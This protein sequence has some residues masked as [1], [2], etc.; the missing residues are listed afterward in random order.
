VNRQS[1]A[2]AAC[3]LAIAGLWS[4][5]RADTQAT[6]T[7]QVIDVE[8]GYVVFANGDALRLAAD[9]RVID[10]HTEQVVASVQPGEY[11][12]ATLDASGSVALLEIS[13]TPFV[14]GVSIDDI[15][16]A[17]VVQLSPPRANPDLASNIPP[18][19]PSK[20]TKS[21]TITI[22][23]FVPSTTP[24][25]ADLYI[26]TDTSGWN[27]QAVKMARIDGRRFRVAMD[28]LPGTQFRYL[29][30]RGSWSSVESDRAGLRRSPR[31]LYA[32]GAV[33]MDVDATIQRWIDLP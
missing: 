8:R 4:A 22:T 9:A 15:P 17:D 18:L 26:T 2:L 6:Y 10:V 12:A 3:A 5:A 32:Q 29:F 16:R 27:P 25:T 30:T 23:A 21:E 1:A 31:S 20:L 11:G 14:S 33:A 28:V 13:E 7:G 19:T 24:F